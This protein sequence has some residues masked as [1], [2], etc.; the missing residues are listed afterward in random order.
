MHDEASPSP[1]R[2]R[3]IH[4]LSRLVADHDL[5]GG[6]DQRELLDITLASKSDEDASPTTYAV[7]AI[8]FSYMDEDYFECRL[9]A[10]R[11]LPEGGGGEGHQQL[12]MVHE[13]C[14][15]TSG[16]S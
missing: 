8:A 1:P 9:G 4:P 3:T 16:S 15:K 11:G 5:P 12:S 2:R 7:I 6:A 10:D 13:L 14:T